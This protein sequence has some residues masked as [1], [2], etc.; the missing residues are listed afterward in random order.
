MHSALGW[1]PGEGPTHDE[2]D[3]L[4]CDLLIVDETSMANLELLVTLLR[5]VGGATHVVLVGDADQLAP[6]GAGKPF[7][8][9]VGLRARAHHSAHPHLPP[10][11]R[12]HDRA[13]G[14]RDPPRSAA[15]VRRARRNAPRPVPDRAAGSP[16]CAGRDRLARQRAAAGAL[17][18]RPGARHPGVRPRVPRRPRH[19]RAQ[20]RAA[21]GAEPRRPAGARR[22]A[23]ARRQA[24]D[25]RAQ[26]PRAGA[27]ERHAAA[28]AR[29]GAAQPGRERPA[30]RRADDADQPTTRQR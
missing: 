5:A 18:R 27:D 1:I 15:A 17:R 28:V 9:L 26:P 6:V 29:R 21:D 13:G 20:P 23:A 16:G 2:Q 3:P 25:D 7:A 22:P 19:R 12:Q 10:G 11:R 30:R 8:E 14:P 4:G 24:D